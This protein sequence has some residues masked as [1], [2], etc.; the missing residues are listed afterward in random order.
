[1]IMDS[2]QLE[3]TTKRYEERQ[4][5]RDRNKRLMDAGR[6]LEVD[7]PERVQK[8]LERRG[9]GTSLDGS[10]V[11]ESKPVV[12]AGEI[13]DLA[14]DAALERVLGTNDLMGVAFLEEGLRAARTIA[15]IWVNVVGG[16]PAGYGTGFMISPRLLITNHHVLGDAATA[17]SSIAEFNYQRLV[18]GTL[19]VS[20][21]F[22]FDPA[23]FFYADRD[24]DYAVVAVRETSDNGGAL[25][26][27]GYNLLSEE[28]GKAIAAQCANIIQ[29][30]GGE[31]K[32]ISLRENQIVDVLPNFLHYE[33][34]T[35]PGASGAAV[36]NDRWEVVAL[37]H[38]GVPKR[39]PDGQILA[40]DGT[41]WRPEMG[42]DRIKWIANEGVRVSR[43]IKHLREQITN[44]A[45]RA[46]FD[47]ILARSQNDQPV[48]SRPRQAQ[49][50]QGVSSAPSA[51]VTTSSDGVAT[52][53]IPLTISIGIGGAKDAAPMASVPPLPLLQPAPAVIAAPV[54]PAAATV[55]ADSPN[56][57]LAKARDAFKGRANVLDVRLGYVFADGRITRERAL[58]VTV[59]AKRSVAELAAGGI[60]ELPPSFGGLKIQVT[61]PTIAELIQLEKGF[62][63]REVLGL[64]DMIGAEITYKP[65]QKPGLRRV[66]AEMKVTA[67]VSPDAGWTQ[68]H[69]FLGQTTKSLTVGMYD[70][71]ARH[72]V[73]AIST[74]GRKR[75][76]KSMTLALQPGQSVGS[77]TKAHDLTDKESVEALQEALGSKFRNAWVKIGVVNG[78]VASSYHI[79]VAVR[80]NTAFWLSSGNWQSSNQPE[81]DPLKKPWERSWLTKYNR[82]W[83]AIVEHAD[84]A[85]DFEKY[86]LH[87]YENNVGVTDE[88]MILPDILL[89]DEVFMPTVTE[90]AAP[91]RYFE[92]FSETRVFDV[93]P[94]LTPDNY[95]QHAMALIE[96]AN[97][98]LLIQN[99]TFNAPKQNNEKLREMLSAILAKQKAGVSVRIIFRILMKSDAR[100]NL[101]ALQDFGFD[102][103]SIKVQKNCHTKGIIADRA[104][105][106]IGSQNLSEQGVSL[107]RDASL[108]FDDAALARYFA[109]I[110]DHDWTGLATSSIDVMP[111][112]AQLATTE[113]AQ[114]GYTTISVD[115]YLETL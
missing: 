98:E 82:E 32:Q 74:A 59:R 69:E 64:S 7:T 104:R 43:I 109:E 103:D 8:F 35:A 106:M 17:R 4:S 36:Y 49:E 86:L 6:P 50:R 16:R 3:Q 9:L 24:L 92:P 112:G 107:N 14:A 87:D 21:S 10:L 67:H 11:T 79:K 80:D 2:Y 73:D 44:D 19:A 5:Q 97:E 18:D 95:H 76:F 51:S 23:V 52:W 85:A 105:V 81:A 38:S 101:E 72:I 99:Q 70:F 83:H 39:T 25:S 53:T 48:V 89:P 31:A 55:R 111:S 66:K 26:E 13:A 115:E 108:V 29:H 110:F 20:K 68:L 88:A 63:A 27:F 46:M 56:E 91:F 113:M 45:Q 78:W 77:G 84:L 40:A 100:K 15:R 62:S 1:M 102:M 57:I 58:V 30:P 94:L 34:D 28:E 75:N 42:D 96:S 37:H 65:P 12:M 60:D 47:A 41:L 33:T 71:G 90:R 54:P 61:D 114:P 22:Q 93:Q